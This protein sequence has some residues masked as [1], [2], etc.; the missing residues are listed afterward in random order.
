MSRPKLVHYVV[1][2]QLSLYG[3]LLVCTALMP[4][5]L[6]ERNEGGASNYGIHALT[7]VPYSLAFGLGG[8]FLLRAA[9]VMPHH[10]SH[11]KLKQVL[12]LLG[13]LLWFVLLTTYPYKLNS[14]FDSVHILATI[15]LTV[16]ELAVGSW[17]ALN[18]FRDSMNIALL[19]TILLGCLLA[20]FTLLGFL[21]TLLIA[22]L[23]TGLS[24]AAVMI[25]TTEQVLGPKKADGKSNQHQ[26]A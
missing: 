26:N 23:I 6:L 21:H 13:I 8:S 22:Q 12:A 15:A 25:R 4:Q 24:F 9:H 10:A 18:L 1:L 5:F 2:S 11:E 3:F 19:G 14:F 16:A 17:F 20:L 7:V